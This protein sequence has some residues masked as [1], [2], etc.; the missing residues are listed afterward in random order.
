LQNTKV[1]AGF[2]G[3]SG[4]EDM[5]DCELALD[6]SF[7]ITLEESDNTGKVFVFLGSLLHFR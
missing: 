6:G 5:V 4:S 7:G 2:M 3:A 1:A